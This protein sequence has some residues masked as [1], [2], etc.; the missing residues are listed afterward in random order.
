M[1]TP[2]TFYQI[3]FEGVFSFELYVGVTFAITQPFVDGKGNTP[4]ITIRYSI[5][6]QRYDVTLTNLKEE[7]RTPE[8]QIQFGRPVRTDDN[9]NPVSP[10]AW[11][12]VDYNLR[13]RQPKIT[14]SMDCDSSDRI[15]ATV[16]YIVTDRVASN[17]GIAHIPAQNAIFKCL[18]ADEDNGVFKV[19]DPSTF[20]AR[21]YKFQKNLS[22]ARTDNIRDNAR[23]SL[24]INELSDS[25]LDKTTWI[26]EMRNNIETGETSFTTIN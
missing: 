19:F 3:P 16:R 25:S 8:K 26:E 15:V 9:G 18:G 4:N 11:D 22:L 17:E 2:R 14:A 1:A 5:A 20:R 7:A 21:Q 6:I 13:T 23:S 10:P 24:V 12:Q